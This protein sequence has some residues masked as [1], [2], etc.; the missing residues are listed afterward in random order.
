MNAIRNR[1]A[2]DE[3]AEAIERSLAM[4]MF[5]PHYDGH[6]QISVR[7]SQVVGPSSQNITSISIETDFL[8][9]ISSQNYQLFPPREIPTTRRRQQPNSGSRR[10][11]L[12]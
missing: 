10:R 3:F 9:D 6:Q 8:P 4:D 11:H 12:R 1:I 7:S 5:E 2:E